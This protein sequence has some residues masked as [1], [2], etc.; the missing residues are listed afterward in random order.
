MRY[1]SGGAKKVYPGKT[2]AFT[3][4]ELLVVIGIIAMLIAILLPTLNRARAAASSIACKSNLRQYGVAVLMYSDATKG[5][6]PDAYRFLDYEYGLLRY[7]QT[8]EATEKITRC[9]AD[10]EMECA[11]LGSGKVVDP[12]LGPGNYWTIEMHRKDGSTYNP[13]C[14]YGANENAMSVS[15]RA[16]NGGRTAAMW[17]KIT[18]KHSVTHWDKSRT[19]LFADWQNNPLTANPPYCIV[20]APSSL[21]MEIG[22]IVFRHSGASNVLFLDGHVGEIRP[23]GGLRIT[24]SGRQITTPWPAPPT[25]APFSYYPFGPRNNAGTWQVFGDYKGLS[26]Q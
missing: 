13:L 21:S 11:R 2:G 5:V 26:I 12:V 19:M 8:N 25:S 14:S 17:T 22:T 3:L 1:R 4:V 18:R 23:A 6:M 20:K 16:I 10:E 9:P 24:S 7:W 15:A